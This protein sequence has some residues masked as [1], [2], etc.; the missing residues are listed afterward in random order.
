VDN[1]VITKL[2]TCWKNGDVV[3]GL[4]FSCKGEN[5]GERFKSSHF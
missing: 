2:I 5:E 4:N 1:D 3:K